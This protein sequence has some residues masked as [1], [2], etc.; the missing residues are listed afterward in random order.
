MEALAT[1]T[2]DTEQIG[3]GIGR[4]T[5]VYAFGFAIGSFAGGFMADFFGFPLVFSAY[6]S[7][8]ALSIFA[9]CFVE[10]PKHMRPTE[11]LPQGGFLSR[12]SSRGLV[13]G[14]ALGASYTFGLA[15]I[16]ALL[17]VYAAG[18]GIAVFWIGAVFSIFWFGRILGAAFAGT[19]SDRLGRRHVALIALVVGSVGFLMIG[20]APGLLSIVAGALLTGLS[21]G[22][23]FPVNVAIIADNV[24]PAL[25]GAAM[26]FYEMICAMAFMVASVFGGISAEVFSPRTP[27]VLSTLIFVLCAVALAVL[28]LLDSKT[29]AGLSFSS[30]DCTRPSNIA[31][32]SFR[33]PSAEQT[34]CFGPLDTLI[35]H[36]VHAHERGTNGTCFL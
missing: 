15:T 32:N 16:M 17:S 20:G 5:T 21:I 6:F 13:T 25:R 11:A 7:V 28:L 27:Y 9:V 22:A 34:R 33:E 24:E 3:R 19:A 35:T 2:A 14:N 36:L 8:A 4:V 31:Q 10:T 12:L 18:F 1:E 26:G 29:T 30:K 23:I